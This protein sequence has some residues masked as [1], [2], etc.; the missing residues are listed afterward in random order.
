MQLSSISI[1]VSVV[2]TIWVAFLELTVDML[3]QFA[4]ELSLVVPSAFSTFRFSLKLS[5]LLKESAASSWAWTN[6]GSSEI[7]R[8]ACS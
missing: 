7:L 5:S 2:S 6:F 8:I 4:P 3:G 1:K